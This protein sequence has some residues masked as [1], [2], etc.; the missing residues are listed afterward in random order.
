MP[1]LY[2]YTHLIMYTANVTLRVTKYFIIFTNRNAHEVDGLSKEDV[3]LLLHWKAEVFDWI[4]YVRRKIALTY[5]K[6]LSFTWDVV[7][8]VQGFI[9]SLMIFFVITPRITSNHLL[10][11]SVYTLLYLR[12]CN[13]IPKVYCE[14]CG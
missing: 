5:F 3:Y 9:I 6:I 13:C 14:P 10:A 4:W 8:L 7:S 1:T 2:I 11:A 12:H